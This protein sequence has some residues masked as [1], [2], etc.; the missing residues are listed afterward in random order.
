MRYDLAILALR[1]GLKRK[2]TTF[3]PI[4]VTSALANDLAAISHH[5]LA[6][7]YG[8]RSRITEI[9]ARELERRLQLDAIDELVSL[10]VQLGD[11]VS[12]LIL[13]LTPAMNNWAFGLE[14]W[15]R[16]KWARGVLAGTDVDISTLIGP[17]DALESIETFMARQTALIRNVSDETRAKV[18]DLVYRGLQQRTPSVKVGRE[19]ANTLAL[20]RRRAN[21]IAADQA[22]KLASALDRQRQREAG[23]DHWKWRHSGK[24]HYRPEHRARDGNIYTDATAPEDEPGELPFCGCVRQGVLIIDGVAF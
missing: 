2:E 21:R 13:D 9:Y 6:G 3:A 16:G 11:E 20:A 8:S 17:T 1:S 24:L 23:L 12:R 18:A 4:L 15:H 19:I 22:T 14:R 5:I 7:W 10:F